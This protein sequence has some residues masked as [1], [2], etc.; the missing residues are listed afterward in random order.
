MQQYRVNFPLLIGLAV[1]TLISSGAVYGLWKFQTERRSGYLVTEAQRLFKEGDLKGAQEYYAQYIRIK[2]TDVEQRVKF[3][4]LSADIAEK[5][6]ASLEDRQRAISI[7]ESTLRDF[8]T[9]RGLRLRLAQ[10]YAKWNVNKDA[11]DHLSFILDDPKAQLLRAQLLA[12]TGDQQAIPY[13]YKLI[14]YDPD[15]D[16]FEGGTAPNDPNTYLTLALLLRK[17]GNRNELADRV[18]EQAAKANPDDPL[19]YLAQGQY[20]YQIGDIE[21]ALQDFEKAYKLGPE[22]AEV[23]AVMATQAM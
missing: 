23:L 6:D 21:L 8:P 7:L 9:E 16:K 20:R 3:A 18:I 13:S 19:S 22:N 14:G 10:M 11:L 1:G 4:E 5:F 2:P 17:D 12:R 15:K